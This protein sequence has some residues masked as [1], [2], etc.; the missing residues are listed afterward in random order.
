MIECIPS[1]LS[2]GLLIFG[3]IYIAGAIRQHGRQVGWVS[4]LCVMMLILAWQIH[5]IFE[6]RNTGHP[7]STHTVHALVGFFLS[8][9]CFLWARKLASDARH[10]GLIKKTLF[11]RETAWRLLFERS[12]DAVFI[13]DQSNRF[14]E[15]NDRGCALLGY[16]REELLRLPSTELFLRDRRPE[17][18]GELEKARNGSPRLHERH[19]VRKDGNVI[20]AEISAAPLPHGRVMATIR[21]VT[22]RKEAEE[23]LKRS[24]FRLAQAAK[25]TG[26]GYFTWNIPSDAVTASDEI[27]QLV[28]LPVGKEL[29]SKDLFDLTHP[30]DVAEIHR[31]ISRALAANCP[32]EVEY[33]ALL[34]DN[35]IRHLHAVGQLSLDPRGNPA[36]VL[37]AVQDVTDR[38]YAEQILKESEDRFR[39]LYTD[40]PAM[41]YSIDREGHVVNVNRTWL[42]TLGYTEEEVLGHDSSDFMTPQSR[43]L[44]LTKVRSDFLNGGVCHDIPF[45]FVHKSGRVLDVLLSGI[46]EKSS[47]GMPEQALVVLRD[48]TA[49]KKAETELREERNL[50]IG[51]PT[52]V[53]RPTI[54]AG[55]LAIEYISPN[56]VEILGFSPEQL[57]A[58]GEF[59]MSLVH[60]DDLAGFHEHIAR[61]LEST[62]PTAEREYRLRK[63]N[64]EFCWVHEFA[65]LNRDSSGRLVSLQAYLTDVTRRKLAEMQLRESEERYRT[66]V[67]TAAEGIWQLDSDGRTTYVNRRM[68]DLLGVPEKEIIGHFVSRFLFPEDC[69]DHERQR[70]ERRRGSVGHYERRFRRTNGETVWCQVS[71]TPLMHKDGTYLGAFAM[72]T[73]LT[74]RKS[75]EVALEQSEAKY[76]ALIET[77]GTGFVILDEE[78]SVLDANLEYLRLTGRSRLR[79]IQGRSVIEWTAPHDRT[80]NAEAV[81][82]CRASGSTRNLEIDYESP[83]LVRTPVEINATVV[84]A[85]GRRRILALCRD[86]SDRRRAALDL[87]ESEERYH[88]LYDT[89]LTGFV[90][91]EIVFN[92]CHTP[93]DFRILD[94][95]PA[96]E[97]LLGTTR[98]QLVGRLGRERFPQF[99]ENR[100][101]VC[102][103][104]ALSGDTYPIQHFSEQLNRYFEGTIFSYKRGQFAVMFVDVSERVRSEFALRESE[105]L[106]RS[107]VDLS[108][109][110]IFIY[111]ASGIV[112]ANDSFVQM[113]RASGG[114]E[115]IGLRVERFMD[116][117]ELAFVHARIRTLEASGG[118]NPLAEERFLRRDGTR[119]DAEVASV[120]I[121]WQDQ[122]AAQIIVRDITERKRSEEERR[123]LEEQLRLSQKLETIGT[124]AAGIAHDFNNLLVPVIGYTELTAADLPVESPGSEHL[125]EVLKAAY[126]AKTLVA[127]ILSFSR[128]QEGEKRPLQL[129]SIVKEVLKML[130]SSLPSSVSMT[131]DV[132]NNSSV[133]L[134]DPTQ[135]HQVLMN[136]CVNASQAMPTGGSLKVSLQDLPGSPAVCPGCGKAFDF[137][138]VH[139]AVSDTGHGMD[140]SIRKRIFDPFFTTKPA[141]KGSGLGLAVTHGI[142][143]QHNGHICVVSEVDRGSTFHIL[144]PAAVPDSDEFSATVL[145]ARAAGEAILLV[146]DDP[147]VLQTITCTL[148]GQGYRVTG[149]NSPEQAVEIFR[150][151]PGAFHLI[152]TDFRMPSMNGDQLAVK[153]LRIRP[154]IPILVLSGLADTHG[155]KNA[156]GIGIRDVL[157][158]PASVTELSSAIRKALGNVPSKVPAPFA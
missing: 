22:E 1:I 93:C 153:S 100:I 24:A 7:T 109:D 99:V 106:H 10:D 17:L 96:A 132:D 98:D 34:P 141:G 105:R 149:C 56:V 154:E 101:Q 158:K 69:T 50:F 140:A 41:M 88:T 23:A 133:V 147:A 59:A 47:G 145:P 157:A 32:F 138:S 54:S 68:A 51:G 28:N 151:Q 4:L 70:A 39:R 75:A 25:L 130:Q 74:N 66:I 15:V 73:D 90:L 49:Q 71:S 125:S 44:I 62:S 38:K 2:V 108:P 136:L 137:S 87:R 117:G 111:T 131:R 107:L 103:Q 150:A 124:L 139:L 53:F 33:R 52:V 36:E 121:K 82:G 79:D 127:Q 43:H 92:E 97:K 76:R 148:E 40:S 60:P 95:N 11:E 14:V 77:T 9:A 8:I 146:D 128:Q 27:Y 112:F 63:S 78:G 94:I 115:L 152:L 55:G 48:I 155:L 6:V 61:T 45:Q 65:R 46:T 80:R 19:L 3:T 102:A 110:G 16:P 20:V 72:L 57:T 83:D 104:A 67:Q 143:S 64:G 120:A 42:E 18:A 21:D 126:R 156:R 123:Q 35:S 144:L 12:S 119:F 84:E 114:S 26:I 118:P 129:S 134:A 135:M 85:D 13:L 122:P 31:A 29:R 116:A 142:I 58:D 86:I 91:C 37:V 81:T 89:M 113:M 30:D 5:P